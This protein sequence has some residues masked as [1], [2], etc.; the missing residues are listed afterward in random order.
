MY[1]MKPILVAQSLWTES[2][3]IHNS[4]SLVSLAISNLAY[5]TGKRLVQPHNLPSTSRATLHR[6]HQRG[7]NSRAT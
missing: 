4:P 6:H 5:S 1:K 7:N 3:D 2:S